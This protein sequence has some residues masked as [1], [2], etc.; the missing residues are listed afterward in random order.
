MRNCHLLIKCYSF[1]CSVSGLRRPKAALTDATSMSN[2][3]DILYS[4]PSRTKYIVVQGEYFVSEQSAGDRN[5]D[6]DRN[7]LMT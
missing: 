4:S 7:I 3:H 5:T 6:D 2:A 1:S